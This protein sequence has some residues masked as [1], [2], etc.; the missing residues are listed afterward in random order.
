MSS[1]TLAEVQ[2]LFGRSKKFDKYLSTV[3]RIEFLDVLYPE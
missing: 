1:A 3:S 2:Q